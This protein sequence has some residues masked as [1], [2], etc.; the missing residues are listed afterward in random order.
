MKNKIAIVAS[1]GGMSCSYSA[2]VL[3][4]LANNYKFTNPDIFVGGSG[5]TGSFSYF[6]AKQ[7]ESVKNIWLNELC[8]P[9]YISFSRPH[10]VCDID[11]L[12]DEVFKKN[13]PLNTKAFNSSKTEAYFALT[14]FNT[15]KTEYF[16]KNSDCIFEVLRAS[17]A[18]PM[19]YR[20][21]VKIGNEIYID[22]NVSS[23]LK[24]YIKMAYEAGATNVL[25][26]DNSNIS[27]G[28]SLAFKTYSLFANKNL[29]GNFRNFQNPE[30]EKELK[31]LTD[32]TSCYYLKFKGDH[33]S[34]ENDPKK[35]K[36]TFQSG[37]DDVLENNDLKQFLM[38]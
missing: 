20:E 24:D 10:R 11:Y 3:Y 34:L 32:Q 17:K 2:G 6:M 22:G 31:K 25:A 19:A 29:K 13:D 36:K 9:K 18:I 15:G 30:R 1:G 21:K 27:L 33:G 12:V 35:M 8:T 28:V 7:Y 26:I 5:C 37:I 4:A 14:N 16:G 38:N 23:S